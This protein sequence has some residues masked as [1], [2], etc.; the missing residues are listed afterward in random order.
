MII[1]DIAAD[2]AGSQYG[3]PQRDPQ[4]H[5]GVLLALDSVFHPETATRPVRAQKTSLRSPT[6][7]IVD[8]RGR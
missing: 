6:L 2:E 5:P 8:P 7:D 1:N 4:R 3:H